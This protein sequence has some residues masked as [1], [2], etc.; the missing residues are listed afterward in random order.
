M[1]DSEPAQRFGVPPHPQVRLVSRPASAPPHMW[2][3]QAA[4]LVAAAE[5]SARS[6]VWRVTGVAGSGVTSLL[7][8]ALTARLGSGAPASS[9]ASVVGV[10]DCHVKGI[11][12]QAAPRVGGACVS[13]RKLSLCSGGDIG[14]V[15]A[16]V[17]VC[18]CAGGVDTRAETGTPVDHRRGAGCGDSGVIVG[19]CR[20]RQGG[21]AAGAAGGVANGGFRQAVA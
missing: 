16:F 5:S 21:M 12:G 7:V 19:A 6:G 11:R 4:E 17:C 10:C 13:A 15:G 14:A 2:Q 1:T 9:G 3:G 18:D 20:G 8:D